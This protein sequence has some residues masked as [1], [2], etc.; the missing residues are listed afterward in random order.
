MAEKTGREKTG[1]RNMKENCA[2]IK[3]MAEALFYW[4]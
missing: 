3:M 1:R 2:N 4:L